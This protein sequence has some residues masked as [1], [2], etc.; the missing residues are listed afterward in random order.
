MNFIKRTV[1]FT[2]LLILTSQFAQA[3]NA[4][5][6]LFSQPQGE[7]SEQRYESAGTGY[8]IVN[9]G[10]NLKK[11][12]ASGRKWSFVIASKNTKA[13]EQQAL[14]WFKKEGIIFSTKENYSL[15]GVKQ[16]N[17]NQTIFVRMDNDDTSARYEIIERQFLNYDTPVT[18]TVSPDHA[19][20]VFYTS[21]KGITMDRIDIDGSSFE[22]QDDQHLELNIYAE[23]QVSQGKLKQSINY[24]TSRTT[25]E[26]TYWEIGDM[27]QFPGIYKWTLSLNAGENAPPLKLMLKKGG[28]IPE[29]KRGDTLGGLLVKNVPYGA[30]TAIPE[31]EGYTDFPGFEESNRVGDV[32]PSGDALFWLPPG[33]WSI[34]V[35]PTDAG[36]EADLL[37]SHF[38]PVQPGKLTQVNWPKSLNDVFAKGEKGKMKILA[39]AVNTKSTKADRA[40]VDIALLG[41]NRATVTPDTKNIE[42]SESGSKGRLL[43]VERIKNPADIV[44]LLDSSGSMKG[45]MKA[46]L[47]ATRKFIKGVPDNA[48]IRVIDFDTEPKLLKGKT[49]KEVLKSLNKVRA[50]GAT[51]LYDSILE[52][53]ELLKKAD[54]PSLIVFTDGVDANYND[55]APGSQATKDEI[56]K[57]VSKAGVPV[58]TIGFGA[59]SDVNTLSR[60][61]QM[62]QGEYYTAADEERLDKVFSQINN[63]LGS[64]Y[65]L[66]YARPKES[67]A[68]NRPVVTI[69]VDNSGSMDSWPDECGSCD[70]RMEKTRQL[71]RRFVDTLPDDFLIQVATFSGDIIVE[72]VL[73]DNKQAAIRGIEQMQGRFTT[74]ILGSMDMSLK[75]LQAVPSTRRYLVYLA[76]AAL[77]VDDEDKKAFDAILGKIKDAGISSLFIGVV[78]GEDE[79]AFAEA[80]NKSNGQYVVSKNFG[81]VS[82][83]F[84]TWTKQILGSPKQKDVS[85]LRV[86]MTHRAKD[87]E[88]RIFSAVKQVRFPKKKIT[89]TIAEPEFVSYRE[90]KP[91]HPYDKSLSQLVSGSDVMMKDVRILKRLPLDISANNKATKI[92][93]KELLSMSR[94][95]GIDA[96]DHLR[97]LAVTLEFENILPSQKVAIY[98]DGSNHPAAWV[99]GN[100][101]PLRYEKRVPTYLIPDVRKHIFLRWNNKRSY[102]VSEVTWLAET[103][104]ILPG[105]EALAVE[106]GSKISGTLIFMVPADHMQQSSLHLYD[107]SYGHIDIPVSGILKTSRNDIEKLPQTAPTQLSDAFS[108]SVTGIEKRQSIGQT[109]TSDD[110][111]FVIIDGHFI[112]NVQAHLDL[113]P[114]ERFSLKLPTDKGNLFLKVHPATS[115]IPL[116]FY[117]PA[118][119]T[120]G[121]K[122]PVKMVFNVPNTLLDNLKNGSVY[123]DIH[124]GAVEVPLNKN[125]KGISSINSA[126]AK[127]KGLELKVVR[128]GMLQTDSDVRI[129]NNLLAVEVIVKDDKD[130]LHT[131]LGELVV[132][133]NKKFDPAKAAETEKK[134]EKLRREAASLPSRGLANFGQSTLK[135]IPGMLAAISSEYHIIGGLD[136][137]STIPDGQVRHG[138]I[139]FEIPPETKPSDWEISSLLIPNLSIKVGNTTYADATLFSKKLIMENE[140]TSSFQSQIEKKMEQLFIEREA[141]SF[142]KPGHIS[143][144][145]TTPGHTKDRGQPVPA[146][147]LTSSGNS[148]FKKV[149]ELSKLQALVKSLRFLPSGAYTSWIYQYLPEAVISQG[150]G[151][152]NDLAVML[153]SVISRMGY[154]AIRTDVTLTDAGKKRLAAL[155]GIDACTL[156]VLPA[157]RYLDST[158]E[159]HLIVSPFMQ[160]AKSL[161]GL[162]IEKPSFVAEGNYNATVALTITLLLESTG[163]SSA[164]KVADMANALGGNDD[165]GLY[166]IKVFNDSL[167]LPELSR[168]AIDIGY[169]KRAVEGGISIGTVI[170]TPLGRYRSTKEQSVST[171]DF[172]VIGEVIE[173]QT[174]KGTYKRKR[175]F[176]ENE[177]ITG[178][179]HTL[180]I[181]LPDITSTQADKLAAIA[182]ERQS[183]VSGTP[184]SLSILKWHTRAALAKF[185]AAQTAYETKLS[186]KLGL[187]IG[188][189][190]NSRVIMVTVTKAEDD[191]PLATHMDLLAPHNQIHK[192]PQDMAT[193]AFR[194]MAGMA[195]SRMEA[196]ALGDNGIGLIKIWQ[197]LPED[198]AIIGL[199][200]TNRERF[201][202]QLEE[203]QYPPSMIEY[204]KEMGYN[205][206]VLF[207]SKG[208][209]INGKSR[210]AWLEFNKDTYEVISIL[211]TGEHGSLAENAIGNPA[212]QAGQYMVG[213]LVGIDVSLWSVAAFSLEMDD[214]KKIIEAAEKFARGFNFGVSEKIGG[215]NFGTDVGGTPAANVGRGPKAEISPDGFK[216]TNNILGFG[217]GYNDG[218]SF[219]FDI[220]K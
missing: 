27:P 197:A 191:S 78:D 96:P 166:A 200:E 176:S 15:F 101:K 150:W 213:V 24:T 138:V 157:V 49:P 207:P 204:F 20:R 121:A 69:M 141:N 56:L 109:I 217:N 116:G 33:M 184:D 52:G 164:S 51:A 38:I 123:I 218:V 90:D 32:T 7:I 50:N 151:T 122:N 185:I 172:N 147:A 131:Q 155:A 63:S 1:F 202:A 82:Q 53:L 75:S 40:T 77:D 196:A 140:L 219:Y 114:R 148:E 59:K 209:T 98:P 153:E 188:R 129:G 93:L 149:N 118:F 111:S 178:V 92:N 64:Q 85:L 130:N 193:R 198:T 220:A 79:K 167:P 106:S 189:T 10:G 145:T 201:I 154:A 22:L 47:S 54:R 174:P 88:N 102:P 212:E 95:R 135:I 177:K 170:D 72:Q 199:D 179:F 192:S 159:E 112:S 195:A 134:L 216:V 73:T 214:Y 137:E 86:N 44:L 94:F 169:S 127:G 203:K 210:W 30:A 36:A 160:E 70:K 180:G 186:K 165:S 194:I 31:Y 81:K 91:L 67:A 119:V 136:E 139:L 187:T 18:L 125:G 57:A 16:L 100:N 37:K 144:K 126:D 9:S 181:N 132:L 25:R 61:A 175:M 110:T 108:F 28:R 76:D 142:V 6:M 182:K 171:A 74:D 161:K 5:A 62:S 11:V 35:D 8:F 104:L 107:T 58:F 99:S 208:A 60:I 19:S 89:A 173:I 23:T 34:H 143:A 71:L 42:I 17:I 66:T 48:R 68:S 14:E 115:L 158:G 124:G 65:R 152:E 215:V 133:K 39:A 146:P 105:D 80:A 45:Q 26:E 211:D 55:T 43:S 163:N 120:P 46:A 117:S 41:V 206:I 4:P 113:N 156:E 103:P 190:H 97:Y 2:L 84:A 87:G 29:L 168:D 3:E 83:T 183:R 12:E 162:V 13:G 128:S 205:K 21:H